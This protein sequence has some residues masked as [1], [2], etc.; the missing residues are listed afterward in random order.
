MNTEELIKEAARI[1]SGAK[2]IVGF[3]G[4]GTSAE[5]GI[6]P[7]RGQ[8]GIWNKY[9]PDALDIENYYRNTQASWNIFREVFY[10]YFNIK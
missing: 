5:S 4:A 3:T 7:F 10:N 2:N 6:P 1:L 8:G 9:D